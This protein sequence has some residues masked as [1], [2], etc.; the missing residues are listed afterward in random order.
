MQEYAGVYL[1]KIT[2]HVSGVHNIH[3][4]EYIKL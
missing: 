2:L 1:Q 4:Q 3:Q